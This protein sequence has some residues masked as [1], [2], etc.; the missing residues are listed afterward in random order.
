M[1][2]LAAPIESFFHIFDEPYPAMRAVWTLSQHLS[3]PRFPPIPPPL[4]RSSVQHPHLRGTSYSFRCISS[5]GP[6]N[7]SAVD[8]STS[9]RI[10]FISRTT[11]SERSYLPSGA[12]VGRR[13][14]CGGNLHTLE[15]SAMFIVAKRWMVLMTAMAESWRALRRSGG[16][17]VFRKG[18][19]LG[20]VLS[21]SLS[22]FTFTLLHLTSFIPSLFYLLP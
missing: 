9:S 12:S 15:L 8:G 6:G 18:P 20:L 4:R 11:K 14:R 19:D 5:T 16:Q 13:T 3:V 22:H 7:L 21:I 10:S 1:L 17:S 2:F